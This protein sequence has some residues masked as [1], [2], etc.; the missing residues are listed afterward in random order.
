VPCRKLRA[1]LFSHKREHEMFQSRLLTEELDPAIRV[2]ELAAGYRD[3]W[4]IWLAGGGGRVSWTASRV[5]KTKR[6]QKG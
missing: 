4:R 3:K 1:F 2:R 5:L 6:L